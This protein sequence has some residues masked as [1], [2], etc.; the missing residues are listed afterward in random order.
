MAAALRVHDVTKTYARTDQPALAPTS[1]EV[2]AG[3][4]VSLVGPSGCGKS[5]LLA[6]IA[7]L[8]TPDTGTVEALGAP[9][10]GPSR[11]CSHLIPARWRP[12]VRR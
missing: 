5:T 3:E 8:L 4:F 10:T 1:F 6:M 2:Q 9:V 11:G 12:W 7:G